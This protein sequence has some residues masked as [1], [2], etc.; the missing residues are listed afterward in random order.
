MVLVLVMV[1]LAVMLLRG[2]SG[3]GISSR[4]GSFD[5]GCSSGRGR[6]FCSRSGRRCGRGGIGEC[7]SGRQSQGG[8]GGDQGEVEKT[9]LETELHNKIK[10]SQHSVF[11]K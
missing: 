6:S 10:T 2:R 9:H 11:L 5:R 1:L 7:R 3:I 4:R 8:N